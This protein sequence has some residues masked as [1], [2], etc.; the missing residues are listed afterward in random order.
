MRSRVLATARGIH[1]FLAVLLPRLVTSL[2]SGLRKPDAADCDAACK[3]NEECL[4]KWSSNK[5]RIRGN[6]GVP[7]EATS[8]L[9]SRAANAMPREHLALYEAQLGLRVGVRG[10][11]KGISF[12]SGTL[13]GPTKAL[14]AAGGPNNA[15]E[16]YSACERNERCAGFTF[17]EL[18]AGFLAADPAA[19]ARLTARQCIL[20]HE[21]TYPLR[22]REHLRACTS[23]LVSKSGVGGGR[24]ESLSKAR[25]DAAKLRMTN[26]GKLGL[27]GDGTAYEAGDMLVANRALK[28]QV[29]GLAGCY[30]ECMKNRECIGF[31]YN[32][33]FQADVRDTATQALSHSKIGEMS[34]FGSKYSKGGGRDV[35]RPFYRKLKP[36]H[37]LLP[38]LLALVNALAS[39]QLD[40]YEFGVFTG[41][42]MV[43]F[44]SKFKNFGTL[45]GL[46]VCGRTR[47]LR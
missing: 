38:S 10:M 23:V 14:A 8:G 24:E 25:A 7:Y 42:R 28:G 30:R 12:H 9:V 19:A 37:Q 21:E 18:H 3:A 46:C 34:S 20:K 4:L 39:P 32:R 43:E 35:Q 5:L 6:C 36:R 15:A 17:K 47:T 45:W 44:A 26:A 27:V 13:K 29:S 31:T 1:V 40:V 11:V 22:T 41:S 16:C 2:D 33:A